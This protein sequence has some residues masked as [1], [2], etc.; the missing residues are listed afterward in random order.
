MSTIPLPPGI[1]PRGQRE[2]RVDDPTL[3]PAYKLAQFHA[4]ESGRTYLLYRDFYV[5]HWD[6]DAF[7]GGEVPSESDMKRARR[8]FRLQ[9]GIPEGADPKQL[10]K[11]RHTL[12]VDEL[13]HLRTV[14]SP[15]SG[16]EI[17][18]SSKVPKRYRKI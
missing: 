16:N 9:R 13:L 17:T 11:L 18:I 14:K 6:E 3:Q 2:F 8:H 12:V 1:A 5:G 4:T 15:I 10:T 7:P